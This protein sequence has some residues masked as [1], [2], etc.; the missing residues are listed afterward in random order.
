[1][2]RA[3][4][5]QLAFSDPRESL[6]KT[7]PLLFGLVFG[8]ATWVV[9]T[10]FT[11]GASEWL[12]ERVG[13]TL[14]NRVRVSPSRSSFGPL[15]LG[16]NMNEQTVTDCKKIPG[17]EAV[18][19]QAHYPGPARM[20]AHFHT[21]NMVTDM[22]LDGVDEA[23]VAEQLPDPS[24]F[25]DS[26]TSMVPVVIPRIMLD[27]LNAGISSHTTLPNLSEQALVGQ[28][29]Q[30]TVG[31]SSFAPGEATN[32]NCTIVG[33]SDQLGPNGPTVPMAWL[34]R[35]AK[36]PVEYHTL[37][38]KLSP[39]ANLDA[40]LRETEK[41]HLVAPDL[42]T[43]RKIGQ[44]SMLA[45][46]LAAAFALAILLV[47]GVGIASG[48]T[49]KVQVEQ[50]DIG[51]Y[52]SLGASRRDII[53][54]YLVRALW[55]GIR[56]ATLGVILGLV[57]GQVGATLILSLLPK[58]LAEGVTLFAPSFVNLMLAMLVTPAVPVVAAW[59]PA[60]QAASLEPGRILR[61]H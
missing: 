53:S 44:A 19:R 55:L 4:L 38:L 25:V 28:V 56:G 18:Y 13:G 51:L 47:A 41:L 2:K 59:I 30:M 1:M 49:V 10:G 22:I 42:E 5:L 12:R 26:T 29:F 33:V 52:R 24:K 54:L 35:N 11:H 45:Q 31:V 8:I 36:R 17:V 61:G 20:Y 15:A 14:P 60:R 48:F 37:T 43:A 40:V 16:S 34:L 23:Q 58:A 3:S 27:V 9:L 21:Q 6:R 32:L 50:A 57:V 46:A 39:N 7:W